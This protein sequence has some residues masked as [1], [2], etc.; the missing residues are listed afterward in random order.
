MR[1]K[2]KT[3]TNLRQLLQRL[4]EQQSIRSI[5]KETKTH[6]NIVRKMYD[7]ALEKE[8]LNPAENM[9]SDA[10]L[11][12]AWY[13]D[14][15]KKQDHPLDPYRE[16]LREWHE[17]KTTT[18]VI[19]RLLKDLFQVKVDVQ[20]I[21]RYFT[22]H[23]PETIRPVMVRETIPG[24]D[25][26]VDYGDLG[27]FEDDDGVV[28]KVYLFSYRLRHSRKA[29]R[30]LVVD[31]KSITFNKGHIH[32]FEFFGGVP[33]KTHPD[34]LKAAVIR[35]SLENSNLNRSYQSLAEYYGFLA[36][37][38]RPYT[39]E[40]KGGVEKDMDYVKR[41]FV[42]HFRITQREIGIKTPK[43]KDLRI[44]FEKWKREVD[45]VRKI[46]GVDRTPNEIFFS[47]EKTQLKPLPKER[48]EIHVWARCTVRADWRVVWENG[49]YSVPYELIGEKIDLCA[50][51]TLVRIFHNHKEVALHE[52]STKKWQYKR[53]AEHA[54]PFKEAV[55]QC[56]RE[57]LLELARDIGE[58]TY[59]Y[60]EK[61][62]STPGVDKLSPVR[63]LLNLADKYSKDK[64]EKACERGCRY[65]LSSYSEI[66]NILASK[67]DVVVIKNLPKSKGKSTSNN[68]KKFKFSRDP[69]EYK[70]QTWD[71]QVE[72]VYPVPKYGNATF[73]AYHARMNDELID[74]LIK[75][76]DLATS[77]GRIGPLEGVK[78]KVLESWYRYHGIPIPEENKLKEMDVLEVE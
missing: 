25:G 37:P 28:K 34:C 31:Q 56:T 55:L 69:K 73:G 22:K 3:M 18:V 47:E 76:E 30:E 58:Y 8:W 74:E 1:G 24:E 66:K 39:P 12:G 43:T 13:F 14:K 62:L 65:M 70:N 4:R 27:A 17:T 21:R 38:C 75:E 9:P 35:A 45:D 41:S 15:A 29:Y 60:S 46:Q 49:Y 67:L 59:Q 42:T 50:T 44:A 23:F 16:K 77:E 40:H 78:P 32:A 26:D 11:M 57:G 61:I 72:S 64:L 36:S 20:V 5:A 51:S 2:E 52:R 54:P 33:R 63:N 10:V 48:W 6:R 19:Q 53:R 71:E 68:S 7:I